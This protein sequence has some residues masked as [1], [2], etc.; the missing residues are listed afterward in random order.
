MVSQV[1]LIAEPWDVG[2][3]GY[4]VGNFPPQW[5]EWNGK[6]RDEVRDFWRGEPVEPRASSRR[7]SPG[8]PTSTRTAAAPGRVDQLRDRARRVHAPRPRLVQREAQRGQRRGRQR[9][10]IAQPVVELGGRGRHRRSRGAR[11]AGAPAAQ[12]PRDA[13][14]L[15]GGADA[16]C[17]ATSSAARSSG[18]NNTYAQDNELSWVHWDARRPAARRVHGRGRAACARTTRRS[19]GAGSSTAAPSRAR[20]APRAAAARH[21]LAAARRHADAA[22]RTGMRRSGGRSACT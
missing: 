1:K 9:R 6:Y 15:A 10:R 12:L 16:R 7:A 4:Q 22:R 18:N 20:R 8:R 14:A 5:T 11:A 3:G 19:A 13:A 2:P 17:T 21:R